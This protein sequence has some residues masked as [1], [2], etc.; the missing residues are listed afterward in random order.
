LGQLV[1]ALIGQAECEG[2]FATAETLL[3]GVTLESETNERREGAWPSIAGMLTQLATATIADQPADHDCMTS[4]LD[5]LARPVLEH[6]SRQDDAA[7]LATPL[8]RLVED[9]ASEPVRLAPA[10]GDC[11]L[12]NILVS[13]SSR[14]ITGV[15][16][17][18]RG[19]QPQ[20]PLVDFLDFAC[21]CRGRAI[22]QSVLPLR[23]PS[24]WQERLVALADGFGLPADYLD[25]LQLYYGLRRASDMLRRPLLA[26]RRR[27]SG[28]DFVSWL[29][30]QAAKLSA[31]R[32]S[33]S[34]L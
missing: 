5:E 13:K 34:I 27:Q 18:D 21:R 19:M 24:Y 12:G 6:I 7:A 14:Q 32:V 25:R 23:I 15:I 2:Q 29:V 10:H 3:P 11:H 26:P 33:M 17:W 28:L 1:P 20:F 31:R 4:L 16:D 22:H 9:L 8:R 30:A